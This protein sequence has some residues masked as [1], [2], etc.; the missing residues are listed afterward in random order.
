MVFQKSLSLWES[1]ALRPGEGLGVSELFHSAKK[2]PRILGGS[3]SH[4][5]SFN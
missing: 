3:K 5:D 4:L 2:I 1:R